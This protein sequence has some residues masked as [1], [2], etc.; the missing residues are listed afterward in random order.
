M[1]Q[2]E[3]LALLARVAELERA[4]K[5]PEPFKPDPD[6]RP[7]NPID[8]VGMPR[9]VMREMSEAI[10]TDMVRE[11]A[12]RDGRAPTGPSS[13]GAIPSSQQV[14]NVRPGGNGTGWQHKRP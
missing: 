11:I 9:S 4:A 3:E 14:S 2:D 13:A 5:P 10:P 7:I 1:T 6:W 12:L 8:R